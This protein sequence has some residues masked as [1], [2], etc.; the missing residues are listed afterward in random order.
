MRASVLVPATTLAMACTFGTVR[1]YEKDPNFLPI[2]RAAAV[3]ADRATLL[4]GS[5]LLEGDSELRLYATSGH[6]LATSP[7]PQGW[8]VQGAA[9]YRGDRL[10]YFGRDVTDEAVWVLHENGFMLPWFS[11]GGAL[12]YAARDYVSPPVPDVAVQRV[13]YMDMTQGPGGDLYLLTQEQ[14]TDGDRSRLW[15]RHEG[16]WTSVA[17]DVAEVVLG[18]AYAVA[19]DPFFDEIYVLARSEEDDTWVHRY[20]ARLVPEHLEIVPSEDLSFVYDI[21]VLGGYVFLAAPHLV[22]I[23]DPQWNERDT[24]P[25]ATSMA[26]ALEQPVPLRDDSEV[27]LWSVG[28]GEFGHRLHRYQL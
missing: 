18:K 1:S 21:E 10:E 22:Q 12:A 8:R 20:S 26:L 19:Y 13:I 4:T 24:A 17:V 16:E 6:L 3:S 25:L 2:D 27:L 5:F 14:R 9:T 7:I 23:R 28:Y 15:R 11:H